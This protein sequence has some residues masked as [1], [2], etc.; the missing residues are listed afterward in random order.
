MDK[1]EPAPRR[2]RYL[3]DL[4]D[5]TK[6]GMLEAVLNGSIP[7]DRTFGY[8]AWPSPIF[9]VSAAMTTVGLELDLEP[10]DRAQP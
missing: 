10:A 6:R 9:A 5:K 8:R 2:L 1:Y 7:G 3:K 4:A